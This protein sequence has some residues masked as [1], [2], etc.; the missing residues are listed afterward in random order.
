MNEHINGETLCDPNKGIAYRHDANQFTWLHIWF[1]FH[2]VNVKRIE[3]NAWKLNHFVVDT[4]AIHF[5]Y[6][7]HNNIFWCYVK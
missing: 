1:F 3:C 2:N 6:K 7:H 5:Q 4:L